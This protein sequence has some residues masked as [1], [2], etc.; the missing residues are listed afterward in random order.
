MLEELTR[1]DMESVNLLIFSKISSDVKMIPNVARHI[2]DSGGKRLRPMLTLAAASMFGSGSDMRVHLAAA[3]IEFIHT[4]TLLHDDV[5]DESELR[6]GKPAAHVIWGNQASILVGD[7]LLSSAFQMIVHTESMKSLDILSNVACTLSE[8]EVLQ[9]TMSNNLETTEE[10]Y[11]SIIKA[12][13]ASLFSAAVEVA[14]IL[15]GTEDCFQ[16][17]L[18]DYGMNLGMAFQLIDDVLDYGG[19]IFKIGKNIGDDL[20]SGKVTLPVIFAF[21]R[22][23]DEEK[24]FW[25]SVIQQGNNSEEN[26]EKAL[27]LIKACNAL[28]DTISRAR[29]YGDLAKDSL[30]CFPDNPCKLAL[31]EVVDFCIERFN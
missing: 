5:V 26:L 7:Y 20:R 31:L 11:I 13:T 3:S 18:K 19:N 10:D 2:I 4:A 25:Y 14:A 28:E 24:A 17:A 29:Y 21:Q 8:G 9:L 22:S 6:R 16:K 12:K 23:S 30:N 15:V 27:M 1:K